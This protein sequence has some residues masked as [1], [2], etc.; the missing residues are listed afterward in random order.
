MNQQCVAK[1]NVGKQCSRK[2]KANQNNMCTQHYKLSS[3][4]Q[5]PSSTV[6]EAP[7]G[8]VPSTD[9]IKKLNQLAKDLNQLVE[10]EKMETYWVDELPPQFRL[11]MQDIE[12]IRKGK[13]VWVFQPQVYE[14]IEEFNFG[15][16]LD[17]EELDYFYEFEGDAVT[18]SGCDTWGLYRPNML[19]EMRKVYNKFA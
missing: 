4:T 9:M 11:T 19:A 6:P 7:E 13:V 14:E 12:D 17:P 8:N 16:G 10:D 18:G 15:G 3:Q 1:T 5:R 2:G